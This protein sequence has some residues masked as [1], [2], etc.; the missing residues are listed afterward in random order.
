M[1]DETLD[2]LVA[3]YRQSAN[4]TAPRR[5]DA[6]VLRAAATR[7][8]A[9]RAWP[10]LGL[11]FAASLA[12]WL[13]MHYVARPSG[14][15]MSDETTRA[16]LLQMDIRPPATGHDAGLDAVPHRDAYQEHP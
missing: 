15:A 16:Y 6:R 3:L 14:A 10:W 2:E 4:E 5:L 13:S 8:A 1:N 9:G 12:L 11:A 7:S